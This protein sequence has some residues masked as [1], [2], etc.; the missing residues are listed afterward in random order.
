MNDKRSF[1]LLQKEFSYSDG[2]YLWQ[3]RFP[4][5]ICHPYLKTKQGRAFTAR[6]SDKICQLSSPDAA[7]LKAIFTEENKIKPFTEEQFQCLSHAVTLITL[8]YIYACRDEEQRRRRFAQSVCL[9][10]SIDRIDLAKLH[11]ELSLLHH[12]LL[13]LDP[14]SYRAMDDPSQAQLRSIILRYA[15]RRRQ[16]PCDA[17]RSYAEHPP[18]PNTKKRTRTALSLFLL[19]FATLFLLCFLLTDTIGT[20]LLTI[21]LLTLSA[22]ITQNLLTRVFPRIPVFSLRPSAIPDKA[23]TLVVITALFTGGH[24]DKELFLKLRRY[25]YRNRSKNLTF[26]ILADLPESNH[27]DAP[28]DEKIIEQAMQQLKNLQEQCQNEQFCLFIRRRSFCATEGSYLGWERKRGA[29]LELCRAAR[30]KKHSFSVC[31]LSESQLKHFR[32]LITLDSDTELGMGGAAEL[33]F[34]MLHPDNEPKIENKVVV[35][36]YGVLQPRMIPSLTSAGKTPFTVLQTGSGGKEA[37]A[38]HAQDFD[39]NTFGKSNFCGKGILDIDAFLETMED[40]FPEERILSHDLLEATRLR[41]GALSDICF[42]DSVPTSVISHCKRQHR[43]MRGDLQSIPFAMPFFRDAKGKKRKNPIGLACRLQILRNLLFLLRPIFCFF[44]IVYALFVSSRTAAFLIFFATLHLT[45]PFVTGL[46]H[47]AHHIHR[48]FYS[49]VLVGCWMSFG[50]MLYGIAVL[51]ESALMHLDALFRSLYRMTVSKKHLLQ[52]VTAES[53]EIGSKNSLGAN[54]WFFKKSLVTG[55]LFLLFAPSGSLF[56][57]GVFTLLF[58]F[59]AHRLSMPIK[60]SPPLSEKDHQTLKTYAAD[61]Y[62]Y[63]SAFVSEESHHLPPDNYQYTPVSRLANRTSATNI[64]MYLLSTLAARDMEILS[65]NELYTRLQN[66]ITTL[67]KLPKYKGHLYNWY[68]TKTLEVLG[69]P[70]VSTVDS[71]N[72]IASLVTLK[73]GILEYKQEQPKLQQLHDDICQLIKECDFT[74]LYNKERHLFCI[75]YDTVQ[76]TQ[77]ENC[78]D[79]YMSEARTASYYCIAKGIVEKKHWQHLARPLLK[80]E[81][82]LGMASWS[83]TGFEY[84][85]PTLFLPNVKNSLQY[86]CLGYALYEQIRDK[87]HGV[88]GRSESGYYAFDNDLNYQYRAFGCHSLA[89]DANSVHHDVIAPYASM[90]CLNMSRSMPLLNLEKLK[91]YDMYGPYGFYEAIDYTPH[92]VGGGYGIVRSYMAHH[93]GMSILSIANLLYENRF[94]RRFMHDAEMESADELLMERIPVDAPIKRR[95]QRRAVPVLSR[96]NLA[97]PEDFTKTVPRQLPRTAALQSPALSVLADSMGF[98]KIYG[99]QYALTY[100]RLDERSALR[101]LRLLVKTD[102]GILDAFQCPNGKFG[103]FEDALVYADKE[104]GIRYQTA[105]TLCC[106]Q[107]ILSLSLELE[108]DFTSATPLLLSEVILAA[109]KDWESHPCYTGLFVECFHRPEDNA[110][111]FRKRAKGSHEK[112]F[113]FIVTMEGGGFDFLCRRDEA[114]VPMYGEKDIRNLFDHPFLSKEGQCI[115][116]FFALRRFSDCQRGKFKCEFLFAAGQ[117]LEELLRHIR[118]YRKA[119]HSSVGALL[120]PSYTEHLKKRMLCSGY[121]RSLVRYEQVILS[122]VLHNTRKKPTE[123]FYA[124]RDLFWRHGISTDLP[125]IALCCPTKAMGQ[126]VKRIL[127]GFLKT[128]K[129][130]AL[131]GFCFDLLIFYEEKEHYGCPYQKSIEALIRSTVGDSTLRRKGGIFPLCDKET[132]RAAEYL[133]PI[134]WVLDDDTTLQKLFRNHLD[135]FAPSS[136]QTAVQKSDLSMLSDKDSVLRL[137]CGSFM[138]NN[139]Y[140]VNKKHCKLPQSYLYCSHQFGTLLT[141]NSAG[142][143]YF[144]NAGEF[145][146][147]ERNTDPLLDMNGERLLLTE[148]GTLYDLC[149]ACHTVDFTPSCAVYYGNTKHLRYEVRIGC[150]SQFPVKGI[151]V[152][153]ENICEKEVNLTTEYR[154]RPSLG[155]SM[156]ISEK[157]EADAVFYRSLDRYGQ[158]EE[159]GMYLC[160]IGLPNKLGVGQS[161]EFHFL[162]GAVNYHNDR[163]YYRVRDALSKPSDLLSAFSRYEAHYRKLIGKFSLQSGAASLDLMFNYYIP[164]QILTARLYGRTGFYQCSGAYG[165][166]DQLQ[167]CLNLLPLTEAP[168]RF[169]ILRCAARQYAEGDVQ[170]WWHES[171]NGPHGMRTRCSDDL[172][173]LPYAV[174]EYI[175][176]TGKTEFQEIKIPYLH[177]P[178]LG[179]KEDERY[180]HPQKTEHKE[181]LRMHCLRAIDRALSRTGEHG[182]LLMG[183]GDWNDGMNRVGKDGRGESV[184]LTMFTVLV[185]ERFCRYCLADGEEKQFYLHKAAEFRTLLYEHCFRQDRFLRGYFDDGSPLG[186]KENEECRIDLL[187]QA[188]SVFIFG[189]NEQSQAAMESAYQTL[190]EKESRIFKLFSPP[191]VK[192]DPDPGYIRGYLAGIRENGGQYTHAAMWGSLAFFMLGQSDRGYEVLCG[193][194]PAARYLIPS[195]AGVYRLEPYALAGDIYAGEH[196]GRGGWSLYTGSAG[197]FYTTVLKGMLGYRCENGKISMSPALPTC[198]DRL[199]LKYEEG[200]SVHSY[201][202]CRNEEKQVQI[203]PNETGG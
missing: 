168:L 40:T 65:T 41:C 89:L 198:L 106:S 199:T 187:P 177:S 122:S 148:D 145:P 95:P 47:C 70:Y 118:R 43:W 75:G 151:W 63:Y 112:D 159:F 48:R 136:E 101:G 27:A 147:T 126:E 162:L 184:W 45:L 166:R 84:F 150:D 91:A 79:L 98:V 111:L 138:E 64:G 13:S 163:S 142:T 100:P 67:Q 123:R 31:T 26:G 90:L 113:W 86:E 103:R 116:P 157:K 81:G 109:Q 173:W 58:P 32:Y 1:R 77:S 190:F 94:V 33:V 72:L 194:N 59:A 197:W 124:G 158:K 74:F 203:L 105:F 97:N 196:E 192:G 83:G 144:R 17:A 121:D 140:R 175:C 62:G 170:H 92:R 50:Q 153:L 5:A 188:F 46:F 68:D 9:L 25:Y 51:S 115:N 24:S 167:D 171:G 69:Q 16:D 71:G 174:A 35:S 38:T 53:V 18:V 28:N 191:F 10:R 29:I 149:A 61:A 93:V 117:D 99:K 119:S 49:S 66:T 42:S 178:A 132:R 57:F 114:F 15:K 82:H 133:C 56:L 182:L 7:S 85:M 107:P 131:G 60:Q 21:P 164:Y 22:V 36:G 88:W 156:L 80:N 37:Y 44:A 172:L 54:L 139:R 127:Q 169:Q 137:P 11:S 76:E 3:A 130:L 120:A 141:H 193:S 73:E 154:L 129:F 195:L 34:T 161:A 125:M 134:F 160:S 78:Y 176:H 23:A 14:H 180:E 146:L 152:Q 135:G 128:Q 102:R 201:L 8:R 2:L 108:G 110:L 55:L 52:W 4:S 186:V 155:K 30:A 96:R 19:F 181:S 12:T 189:K 87:S 165:F 143:T 200:Q 185:L 183:S 202:F 179:E 39:Q 20:L 104:N 6:L